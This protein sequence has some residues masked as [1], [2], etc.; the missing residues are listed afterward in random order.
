[1]KTFL[2]DEKDTSESRSA[3]TEDITNLVFLLFFLLSDGRALPTIK[4]ELSCF[5]SALGSLSFTLAFDDTQRTTTH[6]ASKTRTS[7]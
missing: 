4:T 6:F 5:F 2:L 7:A 3:G 1:M